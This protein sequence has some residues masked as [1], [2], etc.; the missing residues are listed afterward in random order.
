MTTAALPASAS[1]APLDAE[2][3]LV[4]AAARGDSGAFNELFQRHR[5][6]AWRLAQAVAPDRPT[7]AAAFR[8]GFVEALRSHRSRRRAGG[9]AAT[10][11]A[12]VLAAVYKAAV[13]QSYDRSTPAPAARRQLSDPDLALADAAFRSLPE[14]WRGAVWLSDVEGMD[15]ER[16]APILGVSAAVASQLLVRGRRGLAGRFAQAH[17]EA[18]EHPGEVLRA[19]TLP[20]PTNLAGATEARWAEAGGERG[21]VVAPVVAWIEDR[22]VRPMSVAVGALVGLGLIGLGVV[23]QGSPVRSQLGAAGTG[24]LSGA[25]PVQTCMGVA[26]STTGGNGAGQ[27]AL[28]APAGYSPGQLLGVSGLG[29]GGYLGGSSG[30]SAY[31]TGVG[32][33]SGGSA[34]SAGSGTASAPG[35]STTAPGG[36]QGGSAPGSG[37]TTPPPS[38]GGTTPPP[39]GGNGGSTPPT[40]TQTVVALAPVATV[41]SS[42]SSLNVNLLPSGS[43]SA[44]TVTVPTPTVTTPPTTAPSTTSTT[45]TTTGGLTS[46]LSGATSAVTGTLT[47]PL[48]TPTIP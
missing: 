37:G 48:T 25:V 19:V 31:T 46:T 22:A 39:G 10:F 13:T 32:T 11:R 9:S 7:A 17:Q 29:A 5:E 12:E 18:P 1:P 24:G 15:V 41:T 3:Q 20:F 30:T 45:S 14:R 34:G 40:T 8:D 42:G 23:P 44:A 47:Q 4:R 43:G 33:G 27:G 6:P 38:G 2:G 28:A 35:G 16:V 36:S 26:C 21:P